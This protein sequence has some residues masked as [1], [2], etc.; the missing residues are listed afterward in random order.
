M[1]WTKHQQHYI[2]TY[3]EEK[4][5]DK[6]QVL[7]AL[8]SP[9]GSDKLSSNVSSGKKQ[10]PASKSSRV[11]LSCLGAV[12]GS[13]QEKKELF[14]L[15]PLGPRPYMAHLGIARKSAGRVGGGE[16]RGR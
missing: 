7:D 13:E 6:H 14:F 9:H 8:H 2:H 3:P 11:R 10:S 15:F 4:I 1:A 12:V 5:E 16:R